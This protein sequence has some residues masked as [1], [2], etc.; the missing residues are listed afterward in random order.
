[1]KRSFSTLH[2]SSSADRGAAKRQK[3]YSTREISWSEQRAL[4]GVFKSVGEGNWP[5]LGISDQRGVGRKRQY[6]IEWHPHPSTKEQFEP[7]W[8]SHQYVDDDSINEWEQRKKQTKKQSRGWEDKAAARRARQRRV[9]PD[10]SGDV[11]EDVDV[12]SDA[13]TSP[14]SLLSGSSVS[15]FEIPETQYPTEPL[16]VKLPPAPQDKADYESIQSSQLDPNSPSSRL[17]LT[18][19]QSRSH[20]VTSSYSTSYRSPAHSSSKALQPSPGSFPPGVASSSIPT[21]LSSSRPRSRLRRFVEPITEEID[22]SSSSTLLDLASQLPLTGR[23]IPLKTTS[24][25]ESDSLARQKSSRLASPFSGTP[26]SA[27]QV[28]TTGSLT[29]QNGLNSSSGGRSSLDGQA[30]AFSR[31]FRSVSRSPDLIDVPAPTAQPQRLVPSSWAPTSDMASQELEISLRDPADKHVKSPL[32]NSI[33]QDDI[34]TDEPLFEHATHNVVVIE[35][36][37]HPGSLTIHESIED[38]P[39]SSTDT[40]NLL[41]S[42]ASSSQ[43][44]LNNEREIETVDGVMIPALPILGPYEYAI[45]LPAEGKVK[46]VYDEII[47][48]K[49]KDIQRFISRKGSPGTS[50]ISNKKTQER[51]EMQQLLQRLNDTAT[52]TD[53]GLPS[54]Q[55]YLSQSS[56]QN[57]AH[58]EYAGSKFTM[59]GYL[60]EKLKDYTCSIAIFSDGKPVQDLLEEYIKAKHVNV[61]LW[62][63]A[64]QESGQSEEQGLSIDLLPTQSDKAFLL[65]QKP[66]LVVAFDLSFTTGDLQ[67]QSLKRQFGPDLPI[68]HLLVANSSEHVE[69]CVPISLTSNIRLK[70]VVRTTY[71]AAPNLGGEI[72]YLPD[73]SDQPAEDRPMDMSD[74]QRAVRKSPARRLS[75]I[76]DVVAKLALSGELHENWNLGGMPEL[77]LTSLITPP[78]VSRATSRTPQPRNARTQTPVSRATTPLSRKRLLDAESENGAKR[79]RLTPVRDLLPDSAKPPHISEELQEARRDLSQ[80]TAELTAARKALVAAEDY[81]T[82][83]EAKAQQWHDDHASLLHRHEKLQEKQAV[84][85]KENKKLNATV[86]ACKEKEENYQNERLSARQQITDLKAELV[87]ARTELKSGPIEVAQLELAREEARNA[88]TKM[89]ALEKSLKTTKGDFEFT[90]TQYQDASKR[91]VDLASEL[92][93]LEGQ[94]ESLKLAAGDGKRSLKA[95]NYEASLQKLWDKAEQYRLEVK[96][97]EAFIKKLQD[98][99]TTL[100][101]RRGVQTRGS[102]VQPASS[103]AP[104]SR[105]ASPAPGHLMPPSGSRASALRHQH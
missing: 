35:P 44:S 60:I 72:T 51:N 91:A 5:I 94:V 14:P 19:T 41:D 52:H 39:Q 97:R 29:C 33:T 89:I 76:A 75:L 70:V 73:P 32:I 90:R 85:N 65:P 92:R 102:S 2:S 62:D 16:T 10:S 95:M 55:T 13:S 3:L 1:M 7:T 68:L 8:T 101:T 71:L 27:F 48:L 80:V 25:P 53:L 11:A 37:A 84:L 61:R 40:S 66:I 9:V 59:L 17:I 45:A 26:S 78:K 42:K 18:S 103:P 56:E 67:L 47:K 4:G 93:D 57:A 24:T 46:S 49:K 87:Q 6:L 96:S 12:E 54:T 34:A 105:Q 63:S 50:D 22:D 79:Q 64:K 83:A 28:P 100:K 58:S 23:L 20:P 74:I 43:E 81:R 15:G 86:T 21:P 82:A 30:L 36:D 88:I 99:N 98:E 77:K 69:R 31:T 38:D 104:R